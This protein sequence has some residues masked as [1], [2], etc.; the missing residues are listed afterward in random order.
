MIHQNLACDDLLFTYVII[1][2]ISGMLEFQLFGFPL[3]STIRQYKVSV[4]CFINTFR[5]EYKVFLNLLIF[6][7]GAD[8]CGFW[9]QAQYEMCLRWYQL[10]TFYP[11]ARSHNIYK[12]DGVEYA[13]VYI[14]L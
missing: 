13:R 12:N 5:Y 7:I 9:A 8:I 11:F 10:G 3:V 2:V 4:C 6:Q 1:L 14:V